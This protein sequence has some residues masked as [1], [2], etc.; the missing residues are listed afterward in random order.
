MA[1][2]AVGTQAV[3]QLSGTQA[4]RQTEA[5]GTAE[6]LSGHRV[7]GSAVWVSDVVGAGVALGERPESGL[8]RLA[9]RVRGR[10]RLTVVDGVD[11]RVT[12]TKLEADLTDPACG[13]AVADATLIDQAP[14]DW[15]DE[16]AGVLEVEKVGLRTQSALARLVDFATVGVCVK[17]N[18]LSVLQEVHHS[19]VALGAESLFG[20]ALGASDQQRTGLRVD[21]VQ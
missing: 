11:A 13:F 17:V 9:G 10:E 19:E 5:L 12:R 1:G 3:A 20:V 15:L 18:A 16:L 14:G 21:G 8:A 7:K 6:T 2:S 4:C